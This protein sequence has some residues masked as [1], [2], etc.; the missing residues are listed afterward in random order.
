MTNV[1]FLLSY[2]WNQGNL[3]ALETCLI[4]GQIQRIGFFVIRFNPC[5][6]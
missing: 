5:S 3:I 1:T 4:F 6:K 2:C